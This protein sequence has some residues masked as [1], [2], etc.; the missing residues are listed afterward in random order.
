MAWHMSTNE[1]VS[2]LETSLSGL[3]TEVAKES[4]EMVLT[5][6]NFGAIV[7]GFEQFPLTPVQIL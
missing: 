3:G 6:D 5:D 1:V 2:T 7:P 4:A